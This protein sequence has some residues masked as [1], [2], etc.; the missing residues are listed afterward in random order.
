MWIPL[1]TM[2]WQ[3]KLNLENCV[4]LRFTRSPTPYQAVHLI[5]KQPL[6]VVDQYTY[7]GVRLH[8]SMTW[9]HHHGISG[10]AIVNKATKK[11]NFVKRTLYQCDPEVKATTY[12]TL[13][14]PTLEYTTVVWDPHQKHLINGIEM[15]QWRAARWVKQE[16]SIIT[17]VSAI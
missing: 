2:Q 5:N 11:L 7:L 16:Y 1:W 15:V 10:Q 13:V 6:H 3:M 4:T 14:W 17:S 9:S 12:S 8:S